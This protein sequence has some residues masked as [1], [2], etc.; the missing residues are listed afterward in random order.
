M[1]ERLDRVKHYS[2]LFSILVAS[3]TVRVLVGLFRPKLGLDG[4]MLIGMTAV[5]FLAPTLYRV[6]H[7]GELLDTRTKRVTHALSM[8]LSAG[9]FL[10]YVV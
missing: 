2:Y 6:I 8:L 4:S 7:G 9:L 3:M 5:V 1:E 10:Y